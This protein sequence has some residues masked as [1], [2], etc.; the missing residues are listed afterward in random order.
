MGGADNAGVAEELVFGFGVAL[1]GDD[2]A[3]DEVGGVAL[4]VELAHGFIELGGV[5]G[6]GV[7]LGDRCREMIEMFGEP[8]GAGRGE[9]LVDCGFIKG[10]VGQGGL[11]VDGAGVKAAGEFH[12]GVTE[13]GVAGEN[14]GLNR[15]GAAVGR[16]E[17]GVEVEDAGGFKKLEQVGFDENAEGGED[18]EGGGVLALEVGDGGEV[19]GGAGVEDN[20]YARGGGEGSESGVGE[21]AVAKEDDLVGGR[22]G[23]RLVGLG[24]ASLHQE[25]GRG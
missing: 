2:L 13:V 16:Q 1:V 12:N 11:V 18:A 21:G 17:R 10:E 5:G 22:D 3:E 24:G 9:G 23:A 14:G 15:R 8:G 6:V 4:G 20:F 7:V 25:R 19:G